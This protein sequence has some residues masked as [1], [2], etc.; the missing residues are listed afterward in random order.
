MTKLSNHCDTSEALLS[1]QAVLRRRSVTLA[2]PLGKAV[3][4]PFGGVVVVMVL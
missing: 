4:R 1:A 3:T 2:R